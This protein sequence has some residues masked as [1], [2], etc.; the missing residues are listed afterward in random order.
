MRTIAHRARAWLGWITERRRTAEALQFSTRRL[1]ETLHSISDAFFSL[2][3]HLVVTYFNAAAERVLHRSAREVLGRALFDS[4]PEARGSIFEEKYRYAIREK[5]AL[6]FEVDF[7]VAPYADW[8]DVRVYPQANGISVYFQVITERKRTED[9]LRAS[10]RKYRTVIEMTGT[11]YVILDLHGRVLDA[12]QEYVRLSGH[13]ELREIIGRSV[14]EWTA[15]QARQRN[16]EAIAQTAKDGFIRNF[17]TEYTDGDGQP[18]FFVEVNATVE[19]KGESG[20]IVTLCRDVTAIKVAEYE[21]EQQRTELAHLLRVRTVSE[22]SNSL[23]HELNQPLARVLTNAEA[24]QRYLAQQPPDLAETR[25]ILVDVIGDIR[26]AGEV[27]QGLRAHLAPG[28]PSLLLLS[29]RDLVAGAL[30]IARSDLIARGIMVHTP[31]AASVLQVVGDRI[32]LE[33]VLLNLI[34]NAGDAMDATPPARRQLTVA[35]AHRD[36][37]VR[38]SV[39]DT[40]CGLPPDV[41]RIFEPFYSTKKDGLGLGLSICRSIVTAHNGRLSAEPNVAA[42]IPSAAASTRCGATLHLDLPAVDEGKP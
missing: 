7:T 22:L 30:R 11:G 21:L 31:L 20:Q 34:L 18:T 14:I 16:E 41:H 9:L 19:R 36:G 15:E 2:D 12:N 1:Q 40:G 24:A 23:T 3:D 27:I 10:E 37:A 32:Q 42:G 38:I 5:Q 33:Q 8:Y 39:S 35:T 6:T 28:L 26:R 29:V 25:D 4:F 13:G 17:V